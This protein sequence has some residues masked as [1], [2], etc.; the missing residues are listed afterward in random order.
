[1]KSKNLSSGA[2]VSD[3]EGMFLVLDNLLCKQLEQNPKAGMI[4]NKGSAHE[5]RMR[6]KKCREV[7]LEL[8]RRFDLEGKFSIGTCMTCQHF[9]GAYSAT[10]MY[11]KC[12]NKSDYVHAFDTCDKHT[13]GG[14]GRR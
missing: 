9:N 12:P 14:F 13:G 11:G 3:L 10:G 1:M 8:H 2:V 7:L 5:Y 6:Y 4:L